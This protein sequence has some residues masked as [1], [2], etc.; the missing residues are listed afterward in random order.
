MSRGSQ[1]RL[2]RKLQ[3]INKVLVAFLDV[4]LI[5]SKSAIGFWP[6]PLIHEAL[7]PSV[8]VAE[9]HNQENDIVLLLCLWAFY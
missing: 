6:L 5:K 8:S 1:A 9:E 7:Y 2:W 4:H 3:L